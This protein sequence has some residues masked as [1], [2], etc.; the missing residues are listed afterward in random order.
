MQQS[1][2][3]VLNAFEVEFRKSRRTSEQAMEQLSDE[4][5]RKSIDGE[6]NSVAIVVKHLAGNFR[7]RFTNFLTEDGEK[8]WRERDRE[9]IDDFAPGAEGR[10]RMM[11]VWEAGWRCL[12]DSLASLSDSDLG[13]TV[14]V[15]GEAQTVALALSRAL[16]H[17]AYH[18]GQIVLVA[19]VLVGAARWKTLSIPRGGSDAFN[20]SLGFDPAAPNRTPTS[21]P[22]T[23]DR[24]ET[25]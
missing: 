10:A 2:R 11:S 16:G 8:A 6:T 14:R 1:D 18:A 20:R 21:G 13:R 24:A 22:A 4:E 23:A 3:L 5:L 9:F 15:R 19:R 17:T 25:L 7:S 12:F